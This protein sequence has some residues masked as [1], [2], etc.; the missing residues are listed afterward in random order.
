MTTAQIEQTRTHDTAETQQ[1]DVGE[2]RLAYRR[3]GAPSGVPL[4]FLQRFRGTMDNWDP[5][6]VDGLATGRPVILVD[7]RGIGR[8]TGETP[9]SVTA[10]AR[11]VVSFLE[12]LALTQVDL[13]GF[14]LGGMVAQQVLLERPDLVRRAVLAGTGAPGAVD[15]FSAEVTASA[16]KVPGGPAE[17]LFLFFS[18]NPASQAAGVR[19]L[20]RM[21]ARTSREPDAGEPVIRAHLA[22]IRAWG[23]AESATSA[24]LRSI[25]QPVLVVNGSHDIMIP[26]VNSFTLW[27]QLPSAQLI[28]YPDSG[29]GSLFQYPELFVEHATRFLEGE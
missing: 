16:S 23:N 13:L 18:P 26:T 17:L 1:I 4:L 14:S 24:R 3:F 8:S 2:I 19:H 15:M 5:R 11:D 6:V 22:A 27:Q 28:L 9:E 12:V 20:R 29:H 21:V 10:M 7:N 25:E